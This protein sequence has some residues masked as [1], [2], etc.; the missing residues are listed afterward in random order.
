MEKSLGH[1]QSKR[2]SIVPVGQECNNGTQEDITGWKFSVVETE[3]STAAG[4]S[5][6]LDMNRR[7]M[8]F[9]KSMSA[10]FS[11]TTIFTPVC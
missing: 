1:R 7:L 5:I 2:Y 4:S 11:G 6:C 3:A 8:R 10:F 9:H